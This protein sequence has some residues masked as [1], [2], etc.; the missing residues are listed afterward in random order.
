MNKI[1]SIIFLS[2]IFFGCQNEKNNTELEYFDIDET[3]NPNDTIRYFKKDMTPFTGY[4]TYSYRQYFGEKKYRTGHW[5]DEVYYEIKESNPDNFISF[6]RYIN[7]KRDGMNSIYYAEQWNDLYSLL[8][9]NTELEELILETLDVDVL[10]DYREESYNK[11]VFF[12]PKMR[13]KGNYNNGVMNGFFTYYDI[14]GLIVKEINWINGKK[15][16]ERKFYYKNSEKLKYQINFKKLLKNGEYKYYYLNDQ[17]KISG[18]YKNDNITGTWKSYYKDGKLESEKLYKDGELINESCYDINGNKINCNS[19][20]LRKNVDEQ[21]DIG[22]LQK[23]KK[24]IDVYI[25]EMKEFNGLP[26]KVPIGLLN[27]VNED[28]ESI[29][30]SYLTNKTEYSKSKY[31]IKWSDSKDKIISVYKNKEDELGSNHIKELIENDINYIMR[32][33]DTNQIDTNIWLFNQSK[34]GILGANLLF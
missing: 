19:S 5:R 24:Y 9:K 21:F 20:W 8:T 12:E 34:K 16:G 26:M 14:K 18:Q 10:N 4:I 28:N 6:G 7:G 2:I 31:N 11:G 17:I 33:Y 3:T 27:L 32:Y 13:M 25:N 15:D 29:V 30:F 23:R 1:L 22:F